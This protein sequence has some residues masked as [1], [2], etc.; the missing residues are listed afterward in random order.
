MDRPAATSGVET[1]R[2]REIGAEAGARIGEAGA[3][4]S[5]ELND[6]ALTTRIKAKMAL[7]DLVKA[8]DI[9]VSTEGSTVTLRG[10]VQSRAERERA[11][12][13]ARETSGINQVVD[14][15]TVRR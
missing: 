5:A 8:R 2:A 12:Q 1:D 9:S 13:L 6:A 10:T 3:R 11:V 14:R 7:D 4:A 15:L